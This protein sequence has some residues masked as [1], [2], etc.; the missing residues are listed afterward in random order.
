MPSVHIPMPVPVWNNI[1][2][3]DRRMVEELAYRVCRLLNLPPSA[4]YAVQREAEI[5]QRERYAHDSMAMRPPAFS[6]PPTVPTQPKPLTNADSMRDAV[7]IAREKF[8]DVFAA[9]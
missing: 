6:P 7:A 8:P 9:K 3:I 1:P 5:M 2:Q 4:M